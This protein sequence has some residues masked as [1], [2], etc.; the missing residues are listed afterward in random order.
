[1]NLMISGTAS[2]PAPL[3][4]NTVTLDILSYGTGE[5]ALGRVL[6]ARSVKGVCAILVGADHDELG[7]DLAARFP[8]ARLVANEAVVHDD[9]ARIIRLVDNP[10]KDFISSSICAG[11]RFSA[12]SG[13][14]FARSVSAG[15]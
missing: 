13:R 12:A 9:L 2:Q 6:I 5:C 11:R 8:Q 10:Q 14:S 1:M 7:A 15:R 3:A 4:T